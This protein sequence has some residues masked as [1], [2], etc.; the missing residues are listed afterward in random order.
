MEK[1]SFFICWI[2]SAD[3][4]VCS[5]PDEKEGALPFQPSRWTNS[6]SDYDVESPFSLIQSG[7]RLVPA[8]TQQ[9]RH[10]YWHPLRR[11]EAPSP[12]VQD[13]VSD[14][15]YRLRANWDFPHDDSN[16]KYDSAF[17]M[18]TEGHAINGYYWNAVLSSDGKLLRLVAIL[19]RTFSD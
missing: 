7:S 16:P 19:K 2:Q 11:R 13:S 12:L 6:A 14:L 4:S 15:E 3:G 18:A 10:E 17:C 1:N 8:S 5:A 9:L